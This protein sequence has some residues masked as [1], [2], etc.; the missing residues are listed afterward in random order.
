MFCHTHLLS[1]VT[2]QSD[3]LLGILDILDPD[4]FLKAGLAEPQE[5]QLV[6]S[7]GDEVSVCP[8]ASPALGAAPVKLEAANE[9]IH[10]DHIYTKPVEEVVCVEQESEQELKLEDQDQQQEE[11]KEE[12]DD[13]EE[14]EQEQE[15]E[16]FQSLLTDL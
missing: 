13:E 9:L 14:E 10:F 3:I 6:L 11:M 15:V 16:K 5:D 4:L 2:L 1:L 12:D 8:T 7:G